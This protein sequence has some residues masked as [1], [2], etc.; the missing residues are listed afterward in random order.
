M[1][2]TQPSHGAGK[3]SAAGFAGQPHDMRPEQSDQPTQSAPS[4]S[5]ASDEDSE[6]GRF[7]VAEE[8]NF[9]QQSDQ[10]RHVGQMPEGEELGLAGVK[11]SEA[12]AQSAGKDSKNSAASGLERSM[13]R[14]VP[15]SDDAG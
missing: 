8:Q 1:A 14:A 2:N 5:R 6:D 7:S 4:L 9:D 10:A 12:V 11:P 3:D 13:D 15:K